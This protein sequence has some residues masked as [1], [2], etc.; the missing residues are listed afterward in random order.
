MHTVVKTPFFGKLSLQQPHHLEGPYQ[1]DILDHRDGS[2]VG[3][4]AYP[5]TYADNQDVVISW[6]GVA[7]ATW[8]D[9]LIASCGPTQGLGDFLDNVAA[10]N[11]T[12]YPSDPLTGDG[13]QIMPRLLYMRCDYVITYVN[14]L[15]GQPAAVASITVPARDTL[16]TPKQGHV[17]FTD[18]VDEM[19]V[20]Y[21]TGSKSYAPS[22]RYG[23]TSGEY[24]QT[25]TGETTTYSADD[26]CDDPSNSTA[27]Q[28]F[29]D[30]GFIHRV[31]LK[32]LQ[33]NTIY[34]YQFG[35]DD[36]GWSLEWTFKSRPTAETRK[37]KF[38][39][40]AD[41]S[42]DPSPGGGHPTV[43]RALLDMTEGYRDFA[44]HFGDLSY[45]L[46]QAW[47]WDLWFRIIEPMAAQIPYMVSVG[48]HEYDHWHG[49]NKDPSKAPGNGFSPSWGNFANDSRGECGV[50]IYYRFSSPSNGNS[51]FWYSFDY[52]PVHIIQ[53]STEHDWTRGSTQ[54]NWLAS[55]LAAVNRTA[56]P[57]I[58]IT[59]HRMMYTT[60]LQE[61]GDWVV[62]EHMK[63]EMEDLI[64]E[65]KV[66]LMLVGHQHSYERSCAVYKRECQPDGKGTVHIVVGSAGAGLEPGGFSTALGKWSL[67]RIQDWG[68]TRIAAD[69]KSLNIQ[70]LLNSSGEIFD[71]VTLLPWV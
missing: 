19:M 38:I 65:N 30:P 59:G 53:L 7:N 60:Q 49:G 52:G 63:A 20:T 39:A 18:G 70:F 46:G 29:R 23:T 11:N 37:T 21:V 24:T 31:L 71:E 68:Y 33:P 12:E 43:E 32:G 35:N 6:T 8:Q 14:V 45:A 16:G 61:M 41:M 58:V 34:F 62:S 17:G 57:W 10:Y 1:V 50:P 67:A 47:Y 51:V 54:Y 2:T 55:D 26:L 9:Y 22:V 36:E 5:E 44:L 69:D 42:C 4:S 48:N 13:S 66:N 56:T 64:Y 3:M 15:N 28:W 27:Q 40:Y 25:V